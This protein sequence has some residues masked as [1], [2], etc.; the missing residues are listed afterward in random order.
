[1]HPRALFTLIGALVL[2]GG[3]R[4]QILIEAPQPVAIGAPQ[5]VTTVT[6]RPVAFLYQP[7]AILPPVWV[8]ADSTVRLQLPPNATTG[9]VEWIHQERVVATGP[10]FELRKV[11]QADAGTYGVTVR[12]TG[13]APATKH[14]ESISLRIGEPQLRSFLNLSSRGRVA[15][16][17]PDFTAG[18]VLSD[19][20]LHDRYGNQLLVR[21][22]GP[23]LARFGINDFLA[24]PRLKIYRADGTEVDPGAFLVLAFPEGAPGDPLQQLQQR[25]GAFPLPEKSK[26]VVVIVSLP[27]GAYTAVVSS[28]NGGSGTV[29]LEVYEVP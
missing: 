11:S 17:Q 23:G 5:A 14:F 4:S 2:T 20:R 6:L 28:A 21:A 15:S 9:M 3:L 8:Q 18:F 16:G 29:L 10:V 13:G 27:P 12:E 22:V 26:D 7:P 25:V 1:M 19:Q 24:E